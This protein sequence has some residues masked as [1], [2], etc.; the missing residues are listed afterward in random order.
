MRMHAN[1]AQHKSLIMV[2]RVTPHSVASYAVRANDVLLTINDQPALD[3]DVSKRTIVDELSMHGYVLLTLQRDAVD[4][5]TASCSG[6]A[7]QSAS[8]VIDDSY[9]VTATSGALKSILKKRTTS[10]PNLR[11]R[12]DRNTRSQYT[13]NTAKHQPMANFVDGLRMMAV[14]RKHVQILSPHIEHE[15]PRM[16]SDSRFD[17][18]EDGQNY[19]LITIDRSVT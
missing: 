14:H 15:I 16:L 3:R 17:V 18:D 19:T 2:S 8:T 12:N 6:G 10:S 7:T 5:M 11:D 9:Q 1:H 13:P 4:N